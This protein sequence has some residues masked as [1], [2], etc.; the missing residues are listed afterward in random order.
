MKKEGN[1]KIQSIKEFSFFSEA[2]KLKWL[3]LYNLFIPQP[4][5]LV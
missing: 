3:H 4:G 2:K 5:L 1:R